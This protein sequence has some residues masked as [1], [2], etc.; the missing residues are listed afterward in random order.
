MRKILFLAVS[1][2]L[3]FAS[4]ERRPLTYFVDPTM[5]VI[6]NVHWVDMSST[7]SG[8]SIYCY[9]ESGG[10][11]TTTQTNNT[12]KA[13]VNLGAGAYKVLVFNQIPSEYTTIDFVGLSS[14]ETAEVNAMATKS[15]WYESKADDDNLSYEPE[16]LAIATYHDLEIT[17]EE[18]AKMIEEYQSFMTYKGSADTTFTYNIEIDVY[19]AVVVRTTKVEVEVDSI[20][21]LRSVRASVYGMSSG[22]DIS[23]QKSHSTYT[24]HLLESWNLTLNDSISTRGTIYSYF[25]CFG[26]PETTTETRMVSDAWGGTMSLE[27]LLTDGETIHATEHV[28]YDKTTLITDAESSE[29]KS[30]DDE[31]LPSYDDEDVD[32]LIQIDG[33]SLPNM[34]DSGDSGGTSG[35]SGGF[36]GSVNDWSEEKVEI[37]I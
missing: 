37:P 16:E 22:Y 25:T 19:P 1:L 17:E 24:T 3:F 21:S 4:C 2:L 14:Y 12:S 35:G 36:S 31:E 7:P 10:S 32:I 30:G 27:I 9:P 11:P 23:E 15:S 6:I 18:I 28:L 29:N 33:V 26:L 13:T 5:E 34:G 20:A 8:M